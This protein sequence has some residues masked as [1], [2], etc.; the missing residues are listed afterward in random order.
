MSENKKKWYRV[1]YEWIERGYDTVEADSPEEALEY[2][3]ENGYYDIH[4]GGNSDMPELTG[5]V[6]EM[7]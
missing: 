3:R 6:E 2:A 5:D 4:D 1:W 7:T